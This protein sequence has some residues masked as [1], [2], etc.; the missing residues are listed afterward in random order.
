MSDPDL[1]YNS[2][3]AYEAEF[4]RSQAG[5]KQIASAWLLAYFGGLGF[6]LLNPSDAVPQDFRWLLAGGLSGLASI[7]L[8]LLWVLD[9]KIYQ[10]LLHA[11]FVYGLFIEWRR[12]EDPTFLK[13]RMALYHFCSDVSW[14]LSFFYWL[15]LAMIAGFSF[16]CFWGVTSV[17]EV[18]NWQLVSGLGLD[19]EV[20]SG[21]SLLICLIVACAALIGPRISKSRIEVSA[22]EFGEGFAEAMQSGSTTRTLLQQIA[23][24]DPATDA[25]RAVLARKSAEESARQAEAFANQ[26]K[27]AARNAEHERQRTREAASTAIRDRARRSSRD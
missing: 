5:V 17:S 13:P 3:R 18:S 6:L 9:Q 21:M 8:G 24:A 15:P 27:T 16:V 26:S 23:H 11:I 4:N 1:D 14:R 19:G 2:L 22:K 25:N 12:R 20:I 7:G 10:R